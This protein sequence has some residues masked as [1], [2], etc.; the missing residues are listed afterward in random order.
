[1]VVNMAPVADIPGRSPDPSVREPR[2]PATRA[3]LRSTV[4]EDG[5]AREADFAGNSL[6]ALPV[7]LGA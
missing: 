5:L 3:R 7:R 2:I 4:P 1:M 6:R